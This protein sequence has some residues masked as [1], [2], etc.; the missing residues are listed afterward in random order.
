MPNVQKLSEEFAGQDVVVYGL[1]TWEKGG[2]PAAF[3]KQNKFT[4]GLLVHADEV[5]RNYKVNGIPTFYVVGKDGKIL[6]NS[7]GFDE[8]EFAQIKS[9]INGALKGN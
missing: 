7:V 1:S 4:Y 5:S 8:G 2:D 6:F 9:V 3:M